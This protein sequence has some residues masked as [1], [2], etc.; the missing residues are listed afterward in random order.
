M[1]QAQNAKQQQTLNLFKKLLENYSSISAKPILEDV[2][3][4]DSSLFLKT[5]VFAQGSNGNQVG[6]DSIQHILKPNPDSV[7]DLTVRFLNQHYG[8]KNKVLYI[9]WNL[10]CRY[11]L[12]NSKPEID[13]SSI[14]QITLSDIQNLL[15]KYEKE[16]I[17]RKASSACT[18]Y[19]TNPTTKRMAEVRVDCFLPCDVAEGNT[20]NSIS[21]TFEK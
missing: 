19:Y 3:Q 9:Q 15:G 20:I 5:E 8:Q 17:A 2:R 1:V 21:I 12:D 10:H 11:N 4:F 6:L 14:Y 16:R 7:D 13:E 18:F